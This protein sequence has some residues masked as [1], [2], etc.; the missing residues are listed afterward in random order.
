M[1]GQVGS[2]ANSAALNA[3]AALAWRQAGK[4]AETSKAD[5]AKEAQNEALFWQVVE[6]NESNFRDLRNSEPAQKLFASLPEA[7][8]RV[9]TFELTGTLGSYEGNTYFVTEAP[10]MYSLSNPPKQLLFGMAPGQAHWVYAVNEKTGDIELLSSGYIKSTDKPNPQSLGEKIYA[11]LD[12]QQPSVTVI[13]STKQSPARIGS[14]SDK[15]P[16]PCT[17]CPVA[18]A[19]R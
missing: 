8:D 9:R 11:A 10:P 13:Y 7:P 4:G 2:I 15:D 12:G 14:I 3:I 19:G 5:A 16:P 17:G 18:G 6:K 1:V